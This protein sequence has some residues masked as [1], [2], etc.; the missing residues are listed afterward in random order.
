MNID[1]L[2]P[3]YTKQYT[4]KDEHK[5]DNHFEIL[6]DLYLDQRYCIPNS[7]YIILHSFIESKGPTTV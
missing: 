7:L 1:S 6:S 2:Y 4:Y 3:N 5:S